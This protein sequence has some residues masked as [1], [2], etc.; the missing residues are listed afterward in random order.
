[1]NYVL[2]LSGED[3]NGNE[4]AGKATESLVDM[5]VVDK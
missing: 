1:L 4:N 5:K 3:E 2:E